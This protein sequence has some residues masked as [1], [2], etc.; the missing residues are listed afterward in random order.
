MSSSV[1]SCVIQ[2][3]LDCTTLYFLAYIVCVEHA[4][5]NHVKVM[6]LYSYYVAMIRHY[7]LT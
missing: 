7:V 4:E 3:L 1:Q 6:K 2:K 5:M